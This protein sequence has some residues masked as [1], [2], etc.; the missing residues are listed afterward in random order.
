[1]ETTTGTQASQLEEAL[2]DKLKVE[3]WSDFRTSIKR[4]E[5]SVKVEESSAN[6]DESSSMC[7]MPPRNPKLAQPCR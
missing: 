6:D 3:D 2:A 5:E 4:D 1:V 7:K